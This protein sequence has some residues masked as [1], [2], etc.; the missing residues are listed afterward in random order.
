[1]GD[2]DDD[3]A[4]YALFLLASYNPTT[5]VAQSIPPP[6]PPSSSSSSTTTATT[7][8]SSS[9]STTTISSSFSK[10]VPSIFRR[11]RKDLSLPPSDIDDFW[12]YANNYQSKWS[13]LHITLSDFAGKCDSTNDHIVKH[14]SNLILAVIPEIRSALYGNNN[15]NDMIEYTLSDN[16]INNMKLIRLPNDTIAI[17]FNIDN[18]ILDKICHVIYRNGIYGLRKQDEL[19]EG[20]KKDGIKHRLHGERN[21]LHMSIGNIND[22]GFIKRLVNLNI[23]PM[24]QLPL[25]P[26]KSITGTLTIQSSPIPESLKESLRVMTWDISIV[27]WK[28]IKEEKRVDEIIFKEK[29]MKTIKN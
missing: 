17:D 4:Y 6:P 8:S 14:D 26:I 16:N 9:S 20:N 5:S 13:G 11:N 22:I 24:T 18:I 21:K 1:M 19:K 28:N 25:P 7:Q 10:L 12:Q 15:I 27:K 23:N 2:D 3:D 29:L